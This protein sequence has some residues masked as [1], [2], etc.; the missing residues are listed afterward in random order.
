MR[1]VLGLFHCNVPHD[2]CMSAK[3]LALLVPRDKASV[4]RI[5][6]ALLEM[7]GLSK[8]SLT[9]Q[10]SLPM[11]VIFPRKLIAEAVCTAQSTVLI[12]YNC[13]GLQV[14]GRVCLWLV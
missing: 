14:Y 4:K 10:V 13:R 5:V 3:A 12:H 11:D 6:E 7:V 8:L 1:L 2:I 9:A